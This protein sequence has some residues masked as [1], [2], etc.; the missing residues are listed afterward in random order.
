MFHIKQDE[1]N[2]IDNKEYE[3]VLIQ[4]GKVVQ[5]EREQDGKKG[6]VTLLILIFLLLAGGAFWFFTTQQHNLKGTVLE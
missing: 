1:A 2:R 3:K 4:D 6:K 5:K